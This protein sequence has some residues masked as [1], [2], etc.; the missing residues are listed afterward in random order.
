MSTILQLLFFKHLGSYPELDF[1]EVNKS[2]VAIASVRAYYCKPCT[3]D[4]L[5]VNLG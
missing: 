5:K 2:N 4:S 1:Q 3:K